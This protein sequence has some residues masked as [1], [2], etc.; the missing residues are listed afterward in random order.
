[1]GIFSE[2]A[3]PGGGEEYEKDKNDLVRGV[4]AH[5]PNGAIQDAG[6]CLAATAMDRDTGPLKPAFHTKERTQ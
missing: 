2:V 3:V 6:R 1:M 4:R 5:H